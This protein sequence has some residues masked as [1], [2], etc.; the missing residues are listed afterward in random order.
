MLV[1]SKDSLKVAVD[2]L[3]HDIFA[4][5]HL[6][7]GLHSRDSK[8]IIRFSRTFSEAAEK[9]ISEEKSSFGRK[10]LQSVLSLI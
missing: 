5:E 8:G 6:Q 9:L 3:K 4:Y 10:L 2:D 7:K 1:I